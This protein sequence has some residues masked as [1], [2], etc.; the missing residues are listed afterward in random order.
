MKFKIVLCIAMS[1]I[2]AGCTSRASIN[3][4]SN[5]KLCLDYLT[6]PSYNVWKSDREAEIVRRG[7]DCSGYSG[8]AAQKLRSQDN[9]I[10]SL[11]AIGANQP[12]SSRSPNTTSYKQGKFL[13]RHYLNSTGNRVCV[14]GDGT[15]N[16]ING[17]GLCPS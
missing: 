8:I 2:V 10:K 9:A 13:K 16:T 14:Y 4:S 3:T 6:T 12:S 11:Q 5:T 15:V 1:V 7:L 17:I